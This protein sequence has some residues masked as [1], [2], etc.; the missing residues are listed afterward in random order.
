MRWL[1]STRHRL[2]ARREIAKV[3]CPWCGTLTG[4]GFCSRKHAELAEFEDQAAP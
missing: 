1:R 2:I 3:S 4:G